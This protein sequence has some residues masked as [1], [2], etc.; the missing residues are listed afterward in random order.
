MMSLLAQASK[1]LREVRRRF[2]DPKRYVKT[3]ETSGQLQFDLLVREGCMPTSKVLELGCGCLHLAV[4]LVEYL[5]PGNYAGVDPNEWL[6]KKALADADVRQLMETKQVHFL[7]ADDFDASRLGMKF[8]YIFSHSVLSHVAHWQLEQYLEKASQ[9][10]APTGKILSSIRLAE[11]NQF[12]SEGTPD[13]Q[14][15]LHQEWQYPGVSWFTMQT[16]EAFAHKYGLDA[17]LVPE[18]TQ[19]YTQTRPGEFHDWIVFRRR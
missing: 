18:Y 7:T 16:V 13:C 12:G 9:V 2:G 17:T 14:D 19:Y 8:D 3:D 10:L 1:Q 5:D 15:S 4:P 6:R 11:G